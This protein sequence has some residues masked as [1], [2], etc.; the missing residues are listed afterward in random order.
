MKM[1]K[2]IGAFIFALTAVLCLLGSS[3]HAQGQYSCPLYNQLV[4][5]YS[6]DCLYHWS[7][8]GLP[9]PN[10]PVTMVCCNPM[11]IPFDEECVAPRPK[12]G[13]APF[14]ASETLCPSCTAGSPIDL[15][16]GNTYISE[17]DINVPGLGGG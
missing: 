4:A 12:C 3:A 6:A 13:P 17:S 11:G 5:R 9:D 14:A 1:N 10:A 16:T 2:G 8:S 7:S 15:T